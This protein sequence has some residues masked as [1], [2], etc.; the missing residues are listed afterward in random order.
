MLP[1]VRPSPDIT[2]RWGSLAG[3]VAEFVLV[4]NG[5]GA[6]VQSVPRVYCSNPPQY[7][8]AAAITTGVLQLTYPAPPVAGCYFELASAQPGIRTEAG[9]F[10]SAF[11]I[12]FPAPAPPPPDVTEADW[13][14]DHF[15]GTQC[16]LALL[17]GPFAGI[18]ASLQ[19]ANCIGSFGFLTSIETNGLFIILNGS[20][21]FASGDSIAFIPSLLTAGQPGMRVPKVQTLII[22]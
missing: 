10:L 6:I 12:V 11:Y 7:P 18:M 20:G 8:T 17:G 9:G 21:N 2:M 14:I 5:A 3:S 16:Y 4:S 19:I 22:P 13:T 15:S 1:N